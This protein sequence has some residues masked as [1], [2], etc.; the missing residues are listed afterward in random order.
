MKKYSDEFHSF[1]RENVK[2]MKT[3][4]L[5]LLVNLRFDYGMTE[6]QMKAYKNNRG[7][8]SGTPTGMPAGTP[9]KLFPQEITDFIEKNHKGV[10]PKD[11]STLLNAIFGT[12][13]TKER[14]KGY[15]GRFKLNSGLTGYFEKGQVPPNKN[16]KGQYAAGCEKGWFKKGHT[17]KNHRIVGS[18]RVDTDGYT[19]VKTEEP[20][21]WTL[22]HKVLWEKENGKVP[23]GHKLLFKDGDSKNIT[24]ENLMLITDYEM[25][26]LNRKKLIFQDPELTKTGVLIARL[27]GKIKKIRKEG[28]R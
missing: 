23:A 27:D 26:V 11:M 13:F 1:V 16:K 9:S 8:K 25:L 20:D 19:L 18:E 3:R 4:D 15:Y 21:V 17:P 2:G 5:V 6:N 10:G 14:I 12:S 22:K 24:L 7:L 28:K